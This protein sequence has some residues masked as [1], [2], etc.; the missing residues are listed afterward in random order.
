MEH[1]PRLGLDH[2]QGA[3][4]LASEGGGALALP[5]PQPL[6]QRALLFQK[7]DIQ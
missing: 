1:G 5:A 6:H 2:L 3:G 7:T 4:R